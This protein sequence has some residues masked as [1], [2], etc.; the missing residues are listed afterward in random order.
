MG[1]KVTSVRKIG[2]EDIKYLLVKGNKFIIINTLHEDDQE[3]LI[4]GTTL[5]K[6][7][8]IIIN[9]ALKLGMWR[10]DKTF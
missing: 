10:Q 4:E 3:C 2:F 8:V 6:D 9:K 1:N 5:P 7:E